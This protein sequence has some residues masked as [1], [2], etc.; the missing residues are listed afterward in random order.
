MRKKA[1]Q[2]SPKSSVV[3]TYIEKTSVSLNG[4]ITC[5]S[6]GDDFVVKE[7]KPTVNRYAKINLDNEAYLSDEEKQ[8]K[9]DINDLLAQYQEMYEKYRRETVALEIKSHDNFA[10]VKRRIDIDREELKSKIDEIALEMIKKV[11]EYEQA[12]HKRKHESAGIA[13]FNL[14]AQKK[15]LGEEFRQLNINLDSI[16]QMRANIEAN[17]QRLQR[18]MIDLTF[19]TKLSNISLFRAQQRMG[20]IAFWHSDSAWFKTIH[21]EYFYR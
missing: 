16:R 1:T 6:C 18:K 20:K 15:D 8:L 4:L 19:A 21:G 14:D 12:F 3:S 13:E 9:S 5:K 10:E 11:E 17:I 2:N 7:F